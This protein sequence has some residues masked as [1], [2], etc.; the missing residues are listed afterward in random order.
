MWKQKQEVASFA[1]TVKKQRDGGERATFAKP[2]FTGW[3]CPH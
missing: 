2:Q 1:G 3:C